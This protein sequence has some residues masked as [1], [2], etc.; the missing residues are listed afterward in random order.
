MRLARAVTVV[1]A[2][3]GNERKIG[4]RA[5]QPRLAGGC[6]RAAQRPVGTHRISATPWARRRRLA[7][8]GSANDRRPSAAVGLLVTPRGAYAPAIRAAALGTTGTATGIALGNARVPN[9]A[10]GFVRAPCHRGWRP[11]L[12]GVLRVTA[13]GA[14]QE[15]QQCASTSSPRK[16]TYPHPVRQACSGQPAEA[17][18]SVES[19]S[20]STPT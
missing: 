10:L 12:I 11:A 4:H 15:R 8:A 16:P 18:R 20:R 7:G 5:R 3:T 2:V 19:R 6:A 1:R 14:E 13:T 17:R 9:G